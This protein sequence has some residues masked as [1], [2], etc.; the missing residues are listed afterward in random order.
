MYRL[1]TIFIV[2]VGLSEAGAQTSLKNAVFAEIGGSGYYYSINYERSLSKGFLIRGGIG[3][4]TKNFLVPV[5]GGKSF[6]RGNNHFEISGGTVLIFGS[7]GTDEPNQET[8]RQQLFATA[9]AGYRYC[10]PQGKFLFRVGYT[11]LFK[12]YDSY[13]PFN[14]HFLYQWG[15]LSFGYRF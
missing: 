1:A 4:A 3:A 7:I 10:K 11:P 5:L 15:G 12:I 13:S 6:G 2:I 14:N 9:F 8:S